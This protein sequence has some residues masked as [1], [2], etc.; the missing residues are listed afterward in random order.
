M[1]RPRDPASSYLVG[2]RSTVMDSKLAV[3]GLLSAWFATNSYGLGLDEFVIV[4]LILAKIL[5][6]LFFIPINIKVTIVLVLF[7]SGT[8]ES[9]EFIS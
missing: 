8:I 9:Y 7:I 2:L 5:S 3:K 6:H 1:N 4:F